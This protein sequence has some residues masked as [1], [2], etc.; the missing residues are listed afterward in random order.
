MA[1]GSKLQGHI[2]IEL[3]DPEFAAA[4]LAS[5]LGQGDE[6][7]LSADLVNIIKTHGATALSS[8]TLKSID[9][10]S[11]ISTDLH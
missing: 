8:D 7:F 2:E 3:K 1:R 10:N 9:L 4:Y 11:C 6:V 5:A